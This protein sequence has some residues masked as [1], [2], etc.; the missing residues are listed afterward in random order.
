M[1]IKKGDTVQVIAGNAKGTTGKVLK[2]YV[3]EQKVVVEGVNKVTLVLI[4]NILMVELFKRKLLLL[5]LT[6]CITKSLMAKVK[7]QE[8]AIN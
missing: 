1:F 7:Q 2:V 6:L 8:L 4:M 3:K 5:F